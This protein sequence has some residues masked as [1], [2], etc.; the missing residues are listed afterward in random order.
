MTRNARDATTRMHGGPALVEASDRRPI[1]SEARRW[2]AEEDLI[3][4]NLA[5]MDVSARQIEH[6]LKIGR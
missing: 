2:T 1:V 3:D 4:T 5:V 6:P